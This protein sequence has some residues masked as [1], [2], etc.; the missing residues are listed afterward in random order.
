M[1][2]MTIVVW[3]VESLFGSRRRRPDWTLLMVVAG[4]TIALLMLAIRWAL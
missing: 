1:R 3:F 4:I 2:R